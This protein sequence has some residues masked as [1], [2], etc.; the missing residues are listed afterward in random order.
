M[1]YLI[2][3][4][5]TKDS[6]FRVLVGATRQFIELCADNFVF[7][8]FC[9]ESGRAP[10]KP[11]YSRIYSTQR[12]NTTERLKRAALNTLKFLL[13][14]SVGA[15]ILYLVF[16]HQNKA[17]LNDCALKGIPGD[18]CSLLDKLWTDFQGV[19]YGWLVLVLFAFMFSNYS[20]AARW[21]MLVEPLGAT[22]RF[23][24]AYLTIYLGYFFNLLL[25]RLGEVAR[26]GTFARYE[27]IPVEK[28]LGTVVVD[29]IFDA[30]SI[31]IITTLALVLEY[32]TILRF[33][34]A[35]V[36]VSEKIESLKIL[37]WAGIPAGILLLALLWFFRRQLAKTA[38]FTKIRQL[39]HG[40]WQGIQTVRQLDRP[41]LFLLHSINIWLMFY[42]MTY[43][44]FHSYD[45]TSG[46]SPVAALM[47]FVFGGWGIVIPSPGGM[48]TYHFLVQ[49]AL[50]MYGIRGDDG[51]AYA[52]IA[53]FSLQ[54]AGNILL[55]T[56]AL[57]LLPL[58]NKGYHPKGIEPEAG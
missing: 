26:A 13:F 4:Q 47:V 55:G 31:L 6:S 57:I 42:A 54:M 56:I 3:H 9:S 34:E 15:T 44:A 46:L 17:F 8:Y 7:C 12:M 58:L 35:H 5:L 24:N 53:F 41:W 19:H 28:V 25:P 39:L 43:L 40:F 45:P 1:N 36:S 2:R 30:L 14:L 10:P 48:G 37:L 20:R 22:P 52:N 49:T 29:R 11:D 23:R 21:R 32:D 16:Q 50:A 27:R 33:A 18:Q 51:F 38:L